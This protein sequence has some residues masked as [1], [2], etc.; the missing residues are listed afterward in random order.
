[1]ENPPRNA[2]GGG[3]SIEKIEAAIA[4]SGYPLQTHVANVLR[5]LNFNVSPEWSFVDRDSSDLRSMDMR[6]TSELFE[7]N[8]ETRARPSLTVLVECKQSEMPF[9]FFTGEKIPW[10]ALMPFIVGQKQD[11]FTIK[12]DDTL[13]T[14]SCDLQ[15]ALHLRSH[16]FFSAPPVAYTLSK[17]QRKSGSDLILSGD[18]TYNGLVM[19]LVKSLHHLKIAEKP[20]S[21]AVYFDVH[22]AVALGVIDAPM[23]AFE[24]ASLKL[25]PW[26]R[27]LR[28]EAGSAE[29][30]K[31][32]QGSNI[33]VDIVHR[34][35]LETYIIKH[36]FPAA[37]DFSN[38]ILKHDVEV[39]ECEGF[40]S[41]M[42][43]GW[44]TDYEARL[45]PA[46]RLYKKSRSTEEDNS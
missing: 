13:S 32:D 42:E 20:P 17:C 5:S 3:L 45:E 38:K 10:N 19:P 36:L 43:A 7:F 37:K 4:K 18:E 29:L 28:H 8:S 40:I 2:L 6:A 21:T 30:G 46:R 39:A 25:V 15:Q 33:P 22:Y 9:V 34:D 41:G 14:W 12:T 1:M 31:I 24:D 23:V 16:P 26:V 35:F 44:Y 27:V 11:R